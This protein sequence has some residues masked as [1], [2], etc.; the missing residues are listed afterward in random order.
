MKTADCVAI[1]DWATRVDPL[2]WVNLALDCFERAKLKPNVTVARLPSGN[3]KKFRSEKSLQAYISSSPVQSLGLYAT[4]PNYAQLVFGWRMTAGANWNTDLLKTALIAWETGALDRT[5]VLKQLA[6]L[7]GPAYGI[8]FN[9]AFALGP[10]LYV[11]GMVTGYGSGPADQ[12]KSDLVADWFHEVGSNGP[13]RHRNGLLRDVYP[14]NLLTAHHLDHPVGDVTLETWIGA[15]N[16]RGRLEQLFP[17]QWLWSVDEVEI[18]TVR[19]ALAAN[20]LL[21]MSYSDASGFETA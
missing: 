17:G 10:D 20:G 3:K 18:T 15:G 14:L 7:F 6:A 9:R 11:Y 5:W 16:G 21:I 2:A 19:R 8:G 13:N 1:Y 4:R 12:I